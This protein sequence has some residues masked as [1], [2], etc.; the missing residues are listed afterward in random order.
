MKLS[1]S[2]DHNVYSYEI[3]PSSSTASIPLEN[4]RLP[5]EMI[6]KFKKRQ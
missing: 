5:A 1:L 3:E 2:I 6:Q 4:D